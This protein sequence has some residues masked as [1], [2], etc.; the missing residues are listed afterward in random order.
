MEGR[1]RLNC[2]LGKSKLKP[3]EIHLFDNGVKLYRRHL[4]PIQL[5]R[6]AQ[7]NVHEAEEEDVFIELVQRLP[8]SGCYVNVGSA[9]GYYPLLARRIRP[10]IRICA[11]E[12]LAIHRS[13]FFENIRLNGFNVSCFEL[14]EFAISSR[15]GSVVFADKNYSSVMVRDAVDAPPLAA[16]EFIIQSKTLDAFI[17]ELGTQVDLCQM[18]VQ[19]LEVEVLKGAVNSMMERKICGFLIGTHNPKLHVDCLDILKKYKYH[20][21]MENYHTVQQPDGIIAAHYI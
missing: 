5:E 17:N 6:Y 15:N 18:D 7:K 21:S 12:P 14:Y 10:D 19:G 4:L 3:D 11:I 2:C 8:K 20:I 9:V 1:F 13:Y 16:N